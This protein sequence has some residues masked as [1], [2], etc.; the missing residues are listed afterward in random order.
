VGER[1]PHP[2][3]SK[4]NQVILGTRRRCVLSLITSLVL[5]RS[6]ALTILVES[7]E[8][9]NEFRSHS[10]FSDRRVCSGGSVLPGKKFAE[11]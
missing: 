11:E 5:Q 2:L 3:N 10:Y 7:E 9:H 6:E 1:R 4:R 8:N